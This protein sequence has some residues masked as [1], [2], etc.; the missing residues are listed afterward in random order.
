[1]GG[2][3]PI[4]NGKTREQRKKSEEVPRPENRVR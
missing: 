3:L 4:K 1:M 2:V